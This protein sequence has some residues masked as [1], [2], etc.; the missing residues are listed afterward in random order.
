MND[1]KF[2][3]ENGSPVNWS[4][5]VSSLVQTY[6]LNFPPRLYFLKEEKNGKIKYDDYKYKHPG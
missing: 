3:Y 4:K 2:G 6:D 1:A 5:N